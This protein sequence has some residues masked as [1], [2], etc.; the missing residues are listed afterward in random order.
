ML[1]KDMVLR[2]VDKFTFTLHPLVMYLLFC[3]KNIIPHFEFSFLAVEE[4]LN[5]F[6]DLTAVNE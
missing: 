2:H 3:Q 1:L 5:Y 6:H 4:C